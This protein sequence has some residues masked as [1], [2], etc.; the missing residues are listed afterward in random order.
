VSTFS[1][2]ATPTFGTMTV[3]N[4]SNGNV[5]MSVT[6]YNLST[7]LYYGVN[8]SSATYPITVDISNKSPNQAAW[9]PLPTGDYT[10]N[11]T[12]DTNKGTVTKT[13]SPVSITTSA[14]TTVSFSF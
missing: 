6:V 2:S 7:K 3:T 8:G 13:Q 9:T 11:A 4:S 10:V 1:T 5:T 12:A 14:N